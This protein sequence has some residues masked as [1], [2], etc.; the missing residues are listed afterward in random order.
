VGVLDTPAALAAHAL[1]RRSGLL[2]FSALPDAPVMP[3]DASRRA[4]RARRTTRT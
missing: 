2:A 4:R 1:S 3:L